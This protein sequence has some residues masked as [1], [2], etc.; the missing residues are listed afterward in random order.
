MA[1]SFDDTDDKVQDRMIHESIILGRIESEMAKYNSHVVMNYVEVEYPRTKEHYQSYSLMTRKAYLSSL[2]NYLK[3]QYGVKLQYDK[4]DYHRNENVIR[5]RIFPGND[6]YCSILSITLYLNQY[7]LGI[8]H[9]VEL[10]N[11]VKTIIKHILWYQWY[12]EDEIKVR[13][14]YSIFNYVDYFGGSPNGNISIPFDKSFKYYEPF[15]VKS[16]DEILDK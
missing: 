14:F 5:I 15:D 2:N 3:K 16:F 9:I 13:D 10:D 8:A 7:N 12:K 11:M 1:L 6:K 4:S